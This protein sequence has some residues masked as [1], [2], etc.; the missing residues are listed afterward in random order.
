MQSGQSSMMVVS[1]LADVF[2][3]LPDGA[4]VNLEEFSKVCILLVRV[5]YLYHFS[6]WN[7]FFVF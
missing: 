6:L 2:V 7:L 1:N 4:L 5:G 3:P